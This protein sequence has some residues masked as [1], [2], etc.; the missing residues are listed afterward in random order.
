MPRTVKPDGKVTTGSCTVEVR[1][2][3]AAKKA[4][5]TATTLRDVVGLLSLTVLC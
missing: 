4:F 2:R 5:S 3:H 1:I